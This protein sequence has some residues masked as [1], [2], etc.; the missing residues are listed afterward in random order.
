MRTGSIVRIAVVATS[1]VACAKQDQTAATQQGSSPTDAAAVRQA[2]ESANAGLIAAMEKGD[3]TAAASFYD[4]D[5]MTMPQGMDASVGR[6]DI[7]KMFGGFMSGVKIENMKLQVHDVVASGDLAVET[8]HYE[9]T[10]VPKKGKPIQDKG[11]YVVAWKK[12]PDGSWKLF[13]DIFNNDAPPAPPASA[14]K[15]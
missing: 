3:S 2:I 8:G 15:K 4:A 1:L 9:W 12:Q 11:K 14:A 7:Q 13:R 5:A 6:S 10:M